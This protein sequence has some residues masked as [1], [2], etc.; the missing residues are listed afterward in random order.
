MGDHTDSGL[1]PMQSAT[2]LI[3]EDDV[4]QRTMLAHV[5]ERAGFKVVA[6]DD[7]QQA[8]DLWRLEGQRIDALIADIDMPRLNGVELARTIRLESPRLPIILT[9]GRARPAGSLEDTF[10]AKPYSPEALI[11]ILE[12][13]LEPDRSDQGGHWQSA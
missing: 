1:Q 9:S 7:G 4:Q 12:R 6:A 5:L 11:A 3:A 13:L 8:L 2:L 10:I